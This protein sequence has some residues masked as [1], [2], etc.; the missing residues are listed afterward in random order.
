M[1]SMGANLTAG[2][3]EV[4]GRLSAITQGL[5]RRGFDPWSARAAAGRVMGGLVGKQALVLTFEKLF[6]LAGILFLFVLPLLLF[7]KSPDHGDQ[8]KVDVHVEM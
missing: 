5:E 1:V 8:V 7:L 2:R 3:P 6:L 4:V